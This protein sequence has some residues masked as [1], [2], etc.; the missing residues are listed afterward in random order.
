LVL[1]TEC[2]LKTWFEGNVCKKNF[3]S[4]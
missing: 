1:Q 4:R 3:G 2:R